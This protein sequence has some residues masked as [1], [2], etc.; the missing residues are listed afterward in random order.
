M[1]ST[2]A[3]EVRDTLECLCNERLVDELEPS[4]SPCAGKVKGI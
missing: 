2:K 1:Y 3:V 4:L